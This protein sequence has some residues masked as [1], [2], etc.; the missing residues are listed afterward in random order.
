MMEEDEEEGCDDG[1]GRA[2][3]KKCL[4]SMFREEMEAFVDTYDD[5]R[6]PNT[7]I[8]APLARSVC[9]SRTFGAVSHTVLSIPGSH[10]LPSLLLIQAAS[11]F[12]SQ[13][14]L[15][16]ILTPHLAQP[17]QGS[18]E[19]ESLLVPGKEAAVFQ[20]LHIHPEIVHHLPHHIIHALVILGILDRAGLPAAFQG[21]INLIR[22]HEELEKGHRSGQSHLR[23]LL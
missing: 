9:A 11:V 10:S 17:A 1:K 5:L 14:P 8:A 23:L 7:S 13:P 4:S 21:V 19:R 18:G 20:H 6:Y 15:Y 16:P 3:N 12:H 22:R 2:L